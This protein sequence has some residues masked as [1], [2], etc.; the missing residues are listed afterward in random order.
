MQ[1]LPSLPVQDPRPQGMRSPVWGGRFQPRGG[2]G[3]PAKGSGEASQGW[4]GTRPRIQESR[5]GLA[6]TIAS[7]SPSQSWGLKTPSQVKFHFASFC[8]PR[9]PGPHPEVW[10]EIL[11]RTSGRQEIGA[12][13]NAHPA[14]GLGELG[15]CRFPSSWIRGRC[16][17]RI[18][19]WEMEPRK[20]LFFSMRHSEGK[21]HRVRGHMSPGF[22]PF[23]LRRGR[24]SCA[25][26]ASQERL[27]PL[28]RRPGV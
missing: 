6:R 5:Q 22:L 20:G 4:G 21:E 9:A 17:E 18:F 27:C 15:V 8:V 1:S 3:P 25:G 13:L 28:P 11:Q 26:R 24:G 14:S 10:S 23:F 19:C 12:P 7:L 2:Q 16:W